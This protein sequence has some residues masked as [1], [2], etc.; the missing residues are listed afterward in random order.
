MS[1]L[2]L[3]ELVNF[4]SERAARKAAGEPAPGIGKG[5]AL[6]VGLCLLT[7]FT[8]VCNHQVRRRPSAITIKANI[9]LISS[10]GGR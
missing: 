2:L 10:F 5:V 6:A 4:G 9:I 1:P 8:S 3:K 7:I